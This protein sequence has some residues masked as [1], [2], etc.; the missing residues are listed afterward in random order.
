MRI[1]APESSRESRALEEQRYRIVPQ[2]RHYDVLAKQAWLPYVMI[3]QAPG[4]VT[5]SFSTDEHGFRVTLRNGKRL[6]WNEYDACGLPHGVLVGAS[7][8]FGVGASSD[9]FTLTSLLNLRENLV[10]FNFAGRAFNSTQELLIFLLHLPRDLDAVLIFSGLN[11]LMLS[12][13]AHNASPIYSSF[14]SQSVFERGLRSGLVT[15]VRGSSK[16][17]LHELARKLFATDDG[18]SVADVQRKYAHVLAWFRRDMRVWALLQRAI[19]FKLYFVFQP[20]AFW[21]DKTLTPE[22]EEVFGILDRRPQV[23]AWNDVVKYIR[24]RG[25]RYRADVQEV[26]EELNVP[27]LDL[28]ARPSFAERRWLFVDRVH[29]TDEGYA[30]ATEEIRKALLV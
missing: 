9:A 15:G 6:S 21:N 28:N 25:E 10:W 19:G 12:Y 20:T 1:G 14:F 8:A 22:E 26:C 23:R 5:P 29:L 3:F 13:A 30:L 4:I 11:N 18:E 7:A 16:L 24:E 17:L 2:M 27:M